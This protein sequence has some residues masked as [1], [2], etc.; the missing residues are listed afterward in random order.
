[1]F[2]KSLHLRDV[3]S[4]QDL[5][6]DFTAGEG[7]RRRTVLLGANGTGK[8]TVLRAIG[9]LL[10]GSE[11]LLSLVGDPDA[12]IR[13][14]SSTAH[15]EGVLQTKGGETRA[16]G[17]TFTRGQRPTAFLLANQGSLER[18]D[19]ALANSSRNYFTVGY[20]ASR[21]LGPAGL[22]DEAANVDP[23]AASLA[24]LFDRE[25]QLNPLESWAMALDYASDKGFQLV[26]ATLAEVF[27][28]FRFSHIDKTHRQLMFDTADGLVP[29]EQLSD[30][31][32]NLLGWLGDLLYR[33]HRVFENYD[34]PLATRGVL[35]L[36][37]VGLHLHPGLQRQLLALIQDRLPA[38]QL[39]A[40]SHSPLIA[41][42]LERDELKLLRRT[43]AGV[44]LQALDHSPYGLSVD[45]ILSGPLFE[46]SARDPEFEARLARV[47]ARADAGD[48]DAALEILRLMANG[49]DGR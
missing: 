47:R 12:W 48:T 29:L 41:T 2:L 17:L 9:L 33:V 49:A 40:T 26:Q 27:P 45:Q 5:A 22:P 15:I 19:A 3:R 10:V 34:N 23:R 31:Q 46:T 28:T 13:N 18:L 44:V 8:S 7:I 36:D 42:T 35:L 20:G 32:Q 24:T 37:E 38:M 25:T 43:S 6:I 11:G 4:I 21:R 30:G 39:I 16:I 1:M 14:G